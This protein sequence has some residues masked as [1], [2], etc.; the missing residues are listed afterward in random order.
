M[1]TVDAACIGSEKDGGE[2]IAPLREIGEPIMD[3]F[4]QMPAEGLCRFTWT[5]SSRCRLGHHQ[6]IE[7]L[8]DEAIDVFTERSGAESGS[9]L[10][11]TELRHLGGALGRADGGGGL[12][13]LDADFVMFGV[14][15]PMTPEMGEAIESHLDG[16]HEAMQPFAAEGG[17]FNFA[18]R[19][20]DADAILPPNVCP[21]LREVKGRHDP[22]GMFQANHELA[23]A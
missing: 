11:L 9:P 5:P 20:C 4:A 7:E 22:N 8:S 17:Y 16:L 2:A 14:G 21:R 6:V 19:T 18:E 23:A 10:L 12:S 15:L 1:L 3:T 13:H